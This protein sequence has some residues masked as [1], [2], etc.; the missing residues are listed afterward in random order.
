MKENKAKFRN[1]GYGLI[2]AILLIISYKLFDNFADVKNAIG[3]FFDVIAPFLIGI[4]ISYLLYLPV[5]KV[6]KLLMKFRKNKKIKTVT[7]PIKILSI[8]IVYLLVLMF[9][10][11]SFKV[12]VPILVDSI[13]DLAYN[14]QNYYNIVVEK[15]NNLPEDSF[16][17]SATVTDIIEE[18]KNVDFKNFINVER[19]SQYAQGVISFATGIVDFFIAIIVSIYMLA[20]RSEIKEFF[21]KLIKAI[22]KENTYKNISKYFDK[23]NEIFFKYISSQLLDAIIVGILASITMLIMDVKYAVLLG[24]LIGFFNLIPYFG[25]II[26][27]VIAALITILTGGFPQA[28]WMTIVVTIVQQIDANIIGP[29]IV[30]GN[31]KISPLLVIFAVT[32]GGAYFG[33]LGMLL[34][35]PIITI[36]KQFVTDFIDMKIANKN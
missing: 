25:A 19:L 5:K 30:S 16:F 34:A 13:L 23:T 4:L 29:R 1:W 10:A 27:I 33:I 26:A 12:I 9:I 18:L 24:F 6:E 11:I 28:V 32:V 17:R 31:L 21:R 36:I 8:V 2:F 22:F 14:F 20:Q 7:K 3:N 35:V 15:V